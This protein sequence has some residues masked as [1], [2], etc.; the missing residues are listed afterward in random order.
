MYKGLFHCYGVAFMKKI[1]SPILLSLLCIPST[2][3]SADLPSDFETLAAV[4]RGKKKVIGFLGTPSVQE[5]LARAKRALQIGDPEFDQVY[6]AELENALQAK[7]HWAAHSLA[8]LYAYSPLFPEYAKGK[9]LNSSQ[10]IGTRMNFLDV[11]AKNP[12]VTNRP[13]KLIDFMEEIIR[14]SDLPMLVRMQAASYIGYDRHAAVG[15][16]WAECRL[17]PAQIEAYNQ[18][19]CVELA[20]YY[21]DELLGTEAKWAQAMP[22]LESYIGGRGTYA[23]RDAFVVWFASTYSQGRGEFLSGF[24]ENLEQRPALKTFIADA[25]AIMPTGDL[26]HVL[27]KPQNTV[28]SPKELQKCLNQKTRP[29]FNLVL[30]MEAH[31]YISTLN[32][33]K[34]EELRSLIEK[35]LKRIGPYGEGIGDR[36]PFMNGALHAPF[37]RNLWALPHM[38]RLFS[39][40]MSFLP[41]VRK[42]LLHQ[43]MPANSKYLMSRPG[44]APPPAVVR[45][46]VAAFLAEQYLVSVLRH[47]PK[48]DRERPRLPSRGI[49]TFEEDVTA[50]KLLFP[51]RI[52][53]AALLNNEVRRERLLSA[54]GVESDKL[55]PSHK[56]LATCAFLGVNM[57]RWF[58]V[59]C[60]MSLGTGYDFN[61]D[62]IDY[63]RNLHRGKPWKR[64]VQQAF[65]SYEMKQYQVSQ[66]ERMARALQAEQNTTPPQKSTNTPVPS[67]SS[68]RTTNIQGQE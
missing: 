44:V 67:S 7:D 17:T 52:R 63:L 32:E 16:T 45:P 6:R 33:L 14:N 62:F 58:T 60:N 51:A 35:E 47:E 3:V 38:I 22:E 46:D 64:T 59:Y 10:P 21:L 36:N 61:L 12:I 9:I 42:R 65:V 49:K 4:V 24:L 68:A 2:M 37:N 50:K 66:M 13:E 11:L 57:D 34:P 48:C 53:I 29:A 18:S 5:E 43:P 41:W 31:A 26:R 55:P 28:S 54:N 40:D 19:R 8:N 1:L 15:G 25:S 56:S 39:R 30:A 20:A 27:E 23:Y